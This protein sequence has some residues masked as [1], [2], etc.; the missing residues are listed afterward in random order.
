[1]ICCY[2]IYINWQSKTPTSFVTSY[3]SSPAHPCAKLRREIFVFQGTHICVHSA[4]GARINREL[5]RSSMALWS[6]YLSGNNH[7]RADSVTKAVLIIFAAPFC[8][9][10]GSISTKDY[11]RDPVGL[12]NSGLAMP[13][14][15]SLDLK[16]ASRCERGAFLRLMLCTFDHSCMYTV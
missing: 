12:I 6:G 7:R 2:R 8:V 13:T 11:L 1:M 4:S 9:F 5:R 10:L 3:Q 14:Y 15:V 16:C